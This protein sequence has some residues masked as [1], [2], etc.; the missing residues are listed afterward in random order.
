MGSKYHY[1]SKHY[2]YQ[3]PGWNSFAEIVAHHDTKT[4]YHVEDYTVFDWN[5]NIVQE[6]ADPDRMRSRGIYDGE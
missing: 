1:S 2:Y 5:G 3:V 6:P 4:T